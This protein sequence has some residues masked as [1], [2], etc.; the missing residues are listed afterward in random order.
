MEL[1]EAVKFV[2][3]RNKK[4]MHFKE[5]SKIITIEKL[6]ER[7]AQTIETMINAKLALEIKK[8]EKLKQPA[9]FI[10]L[11]NGNIGLI[12]YE[13]PKPV[14]EEKPVAPVIQPVESAP[15]LMNFDPNLFAEL[16]KSNLS[17][18]RTQY[19]EKLQKMNFLVFERILENLLR[20]INFLKYTIVN[21]RTDGGIDYAINFQFFDNNVNMLV[22]VRRWPPSRKISVANIDEVINAMNHHK[23]NAGAV[24]NFSEYE[25]EVREHIK[26]APFPLILLG[27]DNLC[28]LLIKF[29]VGTV[30]NHFETLDIDTPYIKSIEEEISQKIEKH[31]K[32]FEPAQ[33]NEKIDHTR[34]PK[35]HEPKQ[36]RNETHPRNDHPRSEHHPHNKNNVKR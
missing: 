7:G 20:Q 13:E 10:K 3:Q 9:V 22:A 6:V 5:V 32:N 15:A 26:T 28:D 23:F 24:I 1:L 18:T 33:R 25:P 35:K 8:A 27:A 29:N 12:N 36:Q 21:R 4:P 31:K 14:V 16:L 19:V 11:N 34:R 2:L 30:K 17:H